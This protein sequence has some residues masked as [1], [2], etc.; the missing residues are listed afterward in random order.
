MG[1]GAN[2]VVV[3]N[4]TQPHDLKIVEKNCMHD[5]GHDKSNL[6]IWNGVTINP[7]SSIP[8]SG[9]QYI[10]AKTSGSC[11]FESS[12]FKLLIDDTTFVKI[13]E[14]S[15]NYVC[16]EK[17]DSVDVEIDNSGDKSKIS[18]ILK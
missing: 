11:F 2:M 7:S 8:A 10:E 5:K 1:I 14:S 13:V 9:L 3:N 6:Q 17:S 12:S 18:V 15:D 4:D 16:T